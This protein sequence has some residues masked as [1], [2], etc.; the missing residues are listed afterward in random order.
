MRLKNICVALGFFILLASCK[1]DTDIDLYLQDLVEIDKNSEFTTPSTIAIEVSGCQSNKTQVMNIVKKYFEVSSEG[2]CT[3]SN[4]EEFVEFNAKTPI[5]YESSYLPKNI[6]TGV[7]VM[8]GI[9]TSKNIYVVIDKA[10][11]LAMENDVEN[12]DSNASLELNKITINLNND[13][14]NPV[15]VSV[16]A[17]FI[18]NKP[19]IDSIIE[20]N[21][22]DEIKIMLSDV[23]VAL[24]GADGRALVLNIN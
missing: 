5:I 10:R 4:G 17:A 3:S 21:R 16:P 11:F 2:I 22:R 7:L 6:V 18:N 15:K 23:G 8:D 24:V 12:V 14:R 20:L 13:T 1:I 19:A 9:S